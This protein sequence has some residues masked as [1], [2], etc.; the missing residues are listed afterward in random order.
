MKKLIRTLALALALCVA[1]AGCGAPASSAPGGVSSSSTPGSVSSSS[2][3]DAA[4]SG[5]AA[6]P[7]ASSGTEGDGDEAS[8]GQRYAFAIRDARPDEDNQYF[9]IVSGDKDA[10]PFFAVN[11]NGLTDEESADSIRMML[12]TMG[13]DATTLDAYAFSMSMMNVRAYAIGI[14][15]PAEGQEEAV[16]AALEEYVSLQRQAFEQYLADQYEIA[17][18]AVLRTLPGGELVLIMSDGAPDLLTSLEQA[19]A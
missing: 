1:M 13:L 11:P 7:G 19:L 18:N 16:R 5:S 3:P 4:G 15:K 8:L 17:S 12:E 9:E 10:D 14:F 6:A 2:A